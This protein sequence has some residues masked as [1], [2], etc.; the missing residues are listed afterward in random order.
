MFFSVERCDIFRRFYFLAVTL[1]LSG[2]TQ[3]P[4][5]VQ[6]IE[7]FEIERY[8][9]TWHEIARLDHP[10]EKGLDKV[11]A[12]YAMREDGGID[13]VN[14]GYSLKNKSWKEAHG[15]AY[16]VDDKDKGHLKVSF[17]GPFYSSYVIFEIDKSDYQY[18]FVCGYD[19]DY[20]WLLARKPSIDGAII[21][22]FLERTKSL[23]FN[24]DEIIF[25]AQDR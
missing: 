11:T 22:R 9:G 10:F 13:V 2:C 21:E 6:P 8:L 17:F 1:Y 7:G 15:K 14:R 4:E 23:G 3:L 18:A 25:V 24:T 20:L 12:L 5:G 19:K 16:F